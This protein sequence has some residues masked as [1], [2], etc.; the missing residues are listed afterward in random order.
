MTTGRFRIL[1]WTLRSPGAGES[2]NK[3]VF[4][5]ESGNPGVLET[6]RAT[7]PR[8]RALNLVLVE[9]REKEEEGEEEKEKKENLKVK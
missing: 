2:N 1:K 6:H 3:K 4:V 5:Q 7:G 8:I 9:V